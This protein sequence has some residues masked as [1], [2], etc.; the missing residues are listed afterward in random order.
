MR[1][2]Q[3]TILPLIILL[4]Q[5][6][7]AQSKPAPGVQLSAKGQQAFEMLLKADRFENDAIGYAASSSKFVGAY[8]VLLNE[9]AADAAFKSLLENATPAGQLYAL[10][11]IYF[12]DHASFLVIVEKHRTRSD[13]VKFQFGCIGG[14]MR[15]SKIVESNAK[16]VVR[17]EHPSQK[18][19]EW[20]KINAE[21]VKEGYELD[22]LGG[23]YPSEFRGNAQLAP[24]W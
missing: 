17:L 10:C 7:M 18:I 12:T 16:N 22:I 6:V 19:A 8:R 20:Q 4:A 2:F 1:K 15:A 24:G 11:G 5:A 14:D 3:I 9:V 21:L 23:G 13:D